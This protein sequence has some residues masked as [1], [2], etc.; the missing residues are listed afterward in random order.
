MTMARRPLL[1]FPSPCPP[2]SLSQEGKA[3]ITKTNETQDDRGTLT[4]PVP[5]GTV[6]V[7]SV[8]TTQD[9]A[10][11]VLGAKLRSLPTEWRFRADSAA[12]APPKTVFA[13]LCR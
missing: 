5:A 9:L 12:T 2:F 10:Y 1:V 3:N 6:G 4:A 11:P 7:I 13:Y 8:R